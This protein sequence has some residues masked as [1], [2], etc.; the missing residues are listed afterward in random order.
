M[1]NDGWGICSICGA[2]ATHIKWELRDITPPGAKWLDCEPTG[3]MD[4]R[5]DEHLHSYEPITPE[6]QWPLDG[7][8]ESSIKWDMEH[9]A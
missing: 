2:P 7:E 1:S 6:G 3:R 4:R 9:G 8:Y 5:C